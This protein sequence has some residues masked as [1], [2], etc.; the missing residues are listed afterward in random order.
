MEWSEVRTDRGGS[1]PHFKFVH[2]FNTCDEF[3]D[4]ADNVELI[5][6]SDKMDQLS[7]FLQPYKAIVAKS[8][9]IVTI[10]QM[11]SGVF[12]CNDIRKAGT[13]DAFPFMPFLGGTVL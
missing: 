3:K 9:E 1:E 4:R 12:M 13:S 5:I 8:A 6:K 10:I 2:N 11:F 7:E